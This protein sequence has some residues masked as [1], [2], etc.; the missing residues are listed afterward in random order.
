MRDRPRRPGAGLAGAASASRRR[1]HERLALDIR[2]ASRRLRLPDGALGGD[3]MVLVGARPGHPRGLAL[4]AQEND[5]WILTLVGYGAAHRPPA[6]DAGFAGLPRHRRPA[7]R[8]RGDPRCRAARRRSP[9][10]ASRRA[11]AGATT[12]SRRFPAGL[13]VDRRRDLLLQPALRAGHDRRRRPRRGAARLPARRRPRPGEALLRR[14]MAADGRR[15]AALH[16]R[17]P[18]AARGARPPSLGRAGVN[19]YVRRLHAVA[20]HDPVAAAAFTEVVTMHGRPAD[21]L[22]PALALRRGGRSRRTKSMNARAAGGALRSRRQTSATGSRTAG[23]RLRT[24]TAG[25]SRAVSDRGRIAVAKPRA[26]SE[27]SRNGS[28][29]SRA[30]RSGWP[31]SANRCSSDDGDGRAAARRDDRVPGEVG[32]ARRA[33]PPARGR[34]RRRRPPRRG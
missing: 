4:F 14:R 17:R 7:R 34:G 6:D 16:R 9:R 25:P 11:A 1:A 23:C 19:R 5:E 31:A 10:T 24:S 2:Y 13:L 18:R 26:A 29:L 27:R 28:P 8:R 20:E 3:R 32:D 30:R 21:L 12:G 33:A 15:L 22:R